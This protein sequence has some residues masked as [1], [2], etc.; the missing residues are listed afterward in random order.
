M[1]HTDALNTLFIADD[2]CD[3]LA[4][5]PPTV[6][7]L[8]RAYRQM[9][10]SSSGWRK[11]FAASGDEEDRTDQV[12]PCDL[13]L[14]ALAAVAFFRHLDSERPSVLVGLDARPTGRLL[15]LVVVRT[16]LS[17]G[18]SVRYLFIASAPQIMAASTGDG[19]DGF[20]YISASHNPIG[21]NGFKM[22]RAGGVYDGNAAN[23]V[24]AS[25]A[26]LLEEGETAIGFVQE[27]SARL[28]PGLYRR[29]L[30]RVD[31]DRAWSLDRYN[32]FALATAA[33]SDDEAELD[34]FK[35]SLR[36][37]LAEKMLGIVAELNGS[38]RGASIDA[39]FLPAL[40]LQ[41]TLYNDRPG[42][43]VHA[44]VPE[45][46]NL[47][48]CRSLLEARYREDRSYLLGYSVDNDGDRGNIVYIDE[49]TGEAKI[50]D[51]QS[52]YALAL[53]SELAQSRLRNPTGKLATVVNGP[54]S[55]RVDAI[56]VVFDAEVFR[57]EVGEAN[58]VSLADRKREEGWQVPILGEGSNGGNITC[59]AR[60]RDPL[61][62]LVSLVQLLRRREIADLWFTR[63][64]LDL[65]P[66]YTLA[67]IIESLPPFITT[68]AFSPSALMQIDI[69]HGELKRRYEALFTTQWQERTDDLERM[70][71]T[72]Y[73]VYQTEG[74]ECRA[75]L[76]EEHRTPP[77]TGG[78]KVALCDR[79]GKEQAFLW[80]RGSKTEPVFRLMVDLRG[81]CTDTYDYLLAWHRALIE[82]AAAR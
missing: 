76:G 51:A 26:S 33:K 43:V 63:C 24:M 60:V 35:S 10:I 52:V 15:G 72:T 62:T 80:M 50:L 20:F 37:E 36:R 71:F 69:G 11:V 61:N 77:Y 13:I 2:E 40:G 66:H 6:D 48:L 19:C 42:D 4:F 27:A 21:H 68:G 17:L 8:Q 28:D 5:P 49:A 65:P 16:L 81:S 74:L 54:T 41:V 34:R 57:S 22:G 38:A 3:P 67:R 82:Q 46:E 55:M 1:I 78:Y 44:I 79:D 31:S 32:R 59:P 14:T 12:K 64:G 47:D 58:V 70:G 45:G 53:L 73:R 56:A 25:Y 7:E 29:T 9:I 23:A 18:C 30:K 39:T 75:G